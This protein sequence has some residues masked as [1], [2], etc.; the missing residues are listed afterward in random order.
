[1]DASRQAVDPAPRSKRGPAC[2]RGLL[3]PLLA[4]SLGACGG[5][6]GDGSGGDDWPYPLT[7]DTDVA[8]VDLDGDGRQDVLTLEQLA[9]SETDRK[10]RLLFYRQTDTGAFAAPVVTLV[11]SYPW[12]FAIADLDGDGAPDIVIIDAGTDSAWL[13][14]QDAAQRGRF[15]PPLQLATDIHGYDPVIADLNGDGVPDIALPGSGSPPALATI[16]IFYQDPSRAGTFLL[17]ADLP[18]PGNTAHIAAGDLNQDGRSDLAASVLTSGGG[19]TPPTILL[20]YR[21]QQADG[22]LGPF[23]SPA[24]HTGLNVVRLSVADYDGDG[25]QDLFAYLTP[26]SVQYTA[27]LTVVIQD[28]A[29]GT[30]LGAANTRLEDVR[31]LDDAAFADLNRDGRPDAAV[32]GFFPTG[33]PSRVESRVN[34]FTQSGG[35]WFAPTTVHEMPVAVS[36]ITAG[37]LN[38]DGATDLVAFAGD[39]GCVVM[40]QSATTPGVFSPP[41]ALR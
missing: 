36:R 34:L 2:V 25:A 20:G 41:R 33:S 4:V 11:G 8:L 14:W 24:S 1:M 5:G 12:H 22:T 15:E 27:T 32:A 30:F 38:G 9:T 10:G 16:R 40:L 26:Y 39:E 23:T 21:P 31:G 17:A 7:V 37:D 3:P 6:G 35:G 19:T 18:M 29:P 13:L 28:A